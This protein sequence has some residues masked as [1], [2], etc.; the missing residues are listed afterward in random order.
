MYPNTQWA[1]GQS[2]SEGLEE[3]GKDQGGTG[4]PSLS[5]R[6]QDWAAEGS[7]GQ[8]QVRRW[9]RKRGGAPGRG[10]GKGA[11]ITCPTEGAITPHP[12]SD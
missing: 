9:K 11:A 4:L 5:A 3:P 8:H 1:E 12:R 10:W 6:S 2:C 7:K